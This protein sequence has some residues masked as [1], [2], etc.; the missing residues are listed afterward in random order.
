MNID[1]LLGQSRPKK[2][3]PR[4]F[5]E[6]EIATMEGGGEIMPDDVYYLREELLE[7]FEQFSRQSIKE[8]QTVKAGIVQTDVYGARAYH[9]KCLEPNCDWESK[10]YDRIQ[11]A[12][13]AAKKHSEQHFNKKDVAEGTNNITYKQQKG[14]NK[15]SIEMFVD[16]KSA[17][18]FQYDADTGRTLVELDSAFRGQGLGQR[19]ILKGIYTAAMLGMDYVEDESRTQMFDRALDSLADAGY[20]VNDD[21]Y[22]YVTSDGEQFL[23]Q[24]IAENFA[25]GKK[26]GRKGLA[27]RVGVNCKQSVSKLRSIAANSSGERQRMAHW[28][29]NMKSGRNESLEVFEDYDTIDQTLRSAGYTELGSGADATVWTKDSGSVIKI[30]VPEDDDVSRAVTTFKKF[31]EFCMQHQDVE[32]L[33]KFIPIQGRHYAEFTIKDKTF[34]QISMEQ[35][36]PL[37]NNSFHEAMTW[38]LSDFATKNTPWDKVKQILSSPKAWYDS[39]HFDKYANQFALK[40]QN[41]NKI[42]EA[43]LSLLYTVMS[44]L[45]HTGRINK[46]GWDLH[47]ENV[48]QR[49]DGTLVII[50]PWFSHNEN[51]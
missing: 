38:Y 36:Y 2:V 46:F 26:P 30:I 8:S 20:I 24:G 19:L 48:M 28:C 37:K 11:Q 9:A 49:K 51:S 13:A 47:T 14:K 27:K 10:R 3:E 42:F 15:F 22:W 21:E 25:D 23:K 41:L 16:G 6:M 44:L 40:V 32:C 43:K 12:Q 1:D 17:G 33:P 4:R 50:D 39:E 7:R 31:Y 5:T 45:Y 34:V 35:L 18:I 29:A